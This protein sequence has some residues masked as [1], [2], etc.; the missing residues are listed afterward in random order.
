MLSLKIN[1][2]LEQQGKT[3][4]WLSKQTGIS[5][6]NMNKICNGETSI[7]R[8]DTLEK[9]CKALDCSINDLFE[10]NDPQMARLLAYSAKL[11]HLYEE[12]DSSQ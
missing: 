3:M 4:Y 11:A 2:I 6:N 5:P 1:K 10:S 7:I 9:I 12:Q 8:F